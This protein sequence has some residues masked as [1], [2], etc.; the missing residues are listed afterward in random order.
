MTSLTTFI[1]R[2]LIRANYF[3]ERKTLTLGL[4]TL[5]YKFRYKRG[6]FLWR[7]FVRADKL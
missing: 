2:G 7:V 1:P 5:A 3:F 4:I 6:Q